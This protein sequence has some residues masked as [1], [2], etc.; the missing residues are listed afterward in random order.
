MPMWLFSVS[1]FPV[2]SGIVAS[3]P[4]GLGFFENT[5]C[6]NFCGN[7]VKSYP[8]F[9][10][11]SSLERELNFQQNV[12][13]ISVPISFSPW[14]TSC[15][16]ITVPSK[17]EMVHFQIKPACGLNS[18][19]IPEYFLVIELIVYYCLASGSLRLPDN[20]SDLAQL[21]YKYSITSK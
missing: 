19:L 15:G 3:G 9:K 4:N 8:S 1:G 5:P 14:L 13:N 18:S 17:C 21:F 10:I 11:L 2:M 7:F 16:K 20:S 12:Y 6:P